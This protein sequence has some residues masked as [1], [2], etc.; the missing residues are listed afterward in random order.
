MSSLSAL[1][2]RTSLPHLKLFFGLLL[3]LFQ[4]VISIRGGADGNI[5][6]LLIDD[7][8]DLEIAVVVNGPGSTVVIENSILQDT[9]ITGS[10]EDWVAFQA[11]DRATLDISD[12]TIRNINGPRAIFSS[13]GNSVVTIDNVDVIGSTGG[14]STVSH[15]CTYISS[16]SLSLSFLDNAI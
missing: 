16:L 3:Y 6:E 12:S 5:N 10:G 14:Q 9:S 4:S 2:V 13:L 8:N 15:D 1:P 11:R 7:M